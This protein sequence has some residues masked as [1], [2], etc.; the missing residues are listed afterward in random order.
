M[1]AR[2][3]DSGD[4]PEDVL[5]GAL[6]RERA[7]LADLR[8]TVLARLATR[9]LGTLGYAEVTV[10]SGPTASLLDV[11]GLDVTVTVAAGRLIRVTMKGGLVVGGADDPAQ[12]AITIREGSTTLQRGLTWIAEPGTS[13]EV[14][15]QISVLL[16][17]TA[18]EHTYKASVERAGASGGFT[19]RAASGKPGFILVEDLGPA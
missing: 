9:P 18:G 15:V 5:A 19:F 10:N 2:R 14:P 3:L 8:G 17:P 4:T 16:T 1:T 6:A 12:G 7:A 11:P 13:G